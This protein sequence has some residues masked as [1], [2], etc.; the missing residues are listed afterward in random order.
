MGIAY[1]TLVYQRLKMPLLLA[2][3][4]G[5]VLVYYY[6]ILAPAVVVMVA[7]GFSP[8]EFMQGLGQ[9]TYWQLYWMAA[10]L[11]SIEAIVT[12]ILSTTIIAAL[13]PK[14]RRPLW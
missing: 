2:G 4:M 5:L 10:K 8:P 14:Y 3:W 1:K 6:L 7:L 12:L 13:P 9:K 11:G